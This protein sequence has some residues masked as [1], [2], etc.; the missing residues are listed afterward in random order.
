MLI[1]FTWKLLFHCHSFL[2][3]PN[4]STCY[5]SL[6]VPC[7]WEWYL[8]INFPE[9]EYWE[10]SL[11]YSY[12]FLKFM[13]IHLLFLFIFEFECR[14]NWISFV[15]KSTPHVDFI[16]KAQ[17]ETNKIQW[18]IK[19]NVRHELQNDLACL[20]IILKWQR[21]HSIGSFCGTFLNYFPKNNDG[22]RA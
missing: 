5:S 7:V 14:L 12:H 9:K 11:K 6:Y 10:N 21:Q 16:D 17:I 1:Y 3:F 13:I 4:D 8:A 15:Q 19:H 20:K 22:N 2:F 18:C